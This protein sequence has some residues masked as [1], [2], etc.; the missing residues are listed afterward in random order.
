MQM[1]MTTEKT[2]HNPR[3]LRPR[4]LNGGKLVINNGQSVVDCVVRDMNEKGAKVRLTDPTVLP[5]CV[6]LLIVK[7]QMLYPADVR[8][9]R[10][11]EVGLMFSAPGKPTPRRF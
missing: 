8:W 4:V 10:K 3:P 11:G 1:T 7:N 6:E 2:D 9:N 5:D